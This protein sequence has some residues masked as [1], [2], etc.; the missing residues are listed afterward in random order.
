MESQNLLHLEQPDLVGGVVVHNRRMDWG[1]LFETILWFYDVKEREEHIQLVCEGNIWYSTAENGKN[2]TDT[3]RRKCESCVLLHGT[4]QCKLSVSTLLTALFPVFLPPQECHCWNKD[5]LDFKPR[6][7]LGLR[8]GD[9][10]VKLFSPGGGYSFF[11]PF[12]LQGC[13]LLFT[14]FCQELIMLCWFLFP[15]LKPI[16]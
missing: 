10:M 12:W 6:L 1:D 13:G 4:D 3:V 11:V 2:L 8:S 9:V 16:L 5:L 14:N 7:V 15:G